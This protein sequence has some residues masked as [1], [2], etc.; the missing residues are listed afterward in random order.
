VQYA[1]AEQDTTEN[2][3][4]GGA[5]MRGKDVRQGPPPDKPRLPKLRILR[6]PAAGSLVWWLAKPKILG[7][8]THWISSHTVP[9]FGDPAKCEGCASGYN[10]NWK[11]Y[12]I[13]LLPNKRW[14]IV[15]VTPECVWTEPRLWHG[16]YDLVGARLRLWRLG[17]ANNGPVNAALELEHDLR[18]QEPGLDVLELLCAIWFSKFRVPTKAD[19][20]L[21]REQTHNSLPP[22]PP[23]SEDKGGA[24]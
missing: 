8:Y 18:V 5:I 3:V 12:S 22:A 10:P 24:E 2:R 14:G 7:I 6:P 11:G 20:F 4:L 16:D 23:A 1:R 9:C 15:E 19:L 17:R 21:L 13:G